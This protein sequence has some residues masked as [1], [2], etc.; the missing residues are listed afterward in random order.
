M[1]LLNRH[2]DVLQ[3]YGPFGSHDASSYHTH[4]YGCVSTCQC[5]S[6]QPLR[7]AKWIHN[8]SSQVRSA[9]S[10]A[11]LIPW[12]NQT[13]YNR[14]QNSTT[15]GVESTWCNPLYGENYSGCLTH[16]EDRVSSAI[17]ETTYASYDGQ[18]YSQTVPSLRH[19]DAQALNSTHSPLDRLKLTIDGSCCSGSDG[20]PSPYTPS[21]PSNNPS[22]S[23]AWDSC[24]RT[25]ITAV[26][27]Q[28]TADAHVQEENIPTTTLPAHLQS[29][30]GVSENITFSRN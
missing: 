6:C 9:A 4:G 11:K 19:H 15:F 5:A 21:S 18:L 10:S 29:S 25:C 7:Q 20:I 27:P 3:P 23:C 17:S 12:T 13:E 8:R 22:C 16:Q 1:M 2:S 24:T 30:K 26:Q 14:L 28:A